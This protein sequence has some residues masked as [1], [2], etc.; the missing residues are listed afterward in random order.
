M[1]IVLALAF[2]IFP[3]VE[4]ALLIKTGQLIGFW[5]TLGIVI[6]TGFAGAFLLRQQ[7][8]AV[9]NRIG[10][11]LK[12]GRPPLEALADGAML[13]VAGAFLLAPGILTDVAGLLL[14][15]PPVRALVRRVIADRMHVTV[16]VFGD[17]P[18]GF[19]GDDAPRPG[20]R[21]GGGPVIEGE[22]ERLDERTRGPRKR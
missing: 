12:A 7:G 15:L 1:P 21:D 18:Q 17:G 22:F 4:I 11:E 14:L 16:D 3:I 19:P 20:G 10:A 5:P 6:G 2:I 13:L 8:F 9:A